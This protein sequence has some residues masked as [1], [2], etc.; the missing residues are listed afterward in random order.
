MAPA[1]SQN[2]PEAARLSILGGGEGSSDQFAQAGPEATYDCR[3]R[4]SFRGAVC[5]EYPSRPYA[6]EIGVIGA[7][8]SSPSG[9]GGFLC[10]NCEPMPTIL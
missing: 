2:S 5:I 4:P 1:P 9:D 6:H 3:I 10:W 8:E 7:V